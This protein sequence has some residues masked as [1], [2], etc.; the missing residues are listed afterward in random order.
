MTTFSER[1]FFGIAVRLSLLLLLSLL[2][3]SGLISMVFGDLGLGAR[4]EGEVVYILKGRSLGLCVC[5]IG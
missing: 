5:V 3:L 4:R 1:F 2:S